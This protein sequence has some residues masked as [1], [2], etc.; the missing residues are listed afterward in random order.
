M[1]AKIHPHYFVDAKVTCGCGNVF[2]VGSTKEV[3]HVEICFKC[4]P[5]YTGEDRL[6]DT[7]GQVEK[8]KTRQKKAVSMSVKKKEHVQKTRERQRTLKDLLAEA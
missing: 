3:I 8:F 5:L 7:K 6:I 4:H 2:T 1:K